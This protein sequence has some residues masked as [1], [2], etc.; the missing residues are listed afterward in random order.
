MKTLTGNCE[1]CIEVSNIDDALLGIGTGTG[2]TVSTSSSPLKSSI[3]HQNSIQNSTQNYSQ[4]SNQNVTQSYENV[5]NELPSIFLKGERP[6]S[7]RSDT[8]SYLGTINTGIGTMLS[9]HEQEELRI[10]LNNEREKTI[11]L[12][13]ALQL[14]DEENNM[15][16]K[17]QMKN[18]N[19]YNN[20]NNNININN[21]ENENGTDKLSARTLLNTT[22]FF[23]SK[24]N[25]NIHSNT[26]MNFNFINLNM[27]HTNTLSR[28]PSRIIRE[29]N[30]R[31][32]WL[33]KASKSSTFTS[34]VSSLSSIWKTKFVELRH[35]VFSYEDD[36]SNTK[37]TNKKNILLS[38]DTCYCDVLKMREKDGDFVFELSMKNGNRRLWQA[39]SIRDRDA[40]INAINSG[41]MRNNDSFLQSNALSINNN[42]NDDSNSNNNNHHNNNTMQFLLDQSMGLNDNKN[43]NNSNNSIITSS[44]G[45]AAP[46]TNEISRFFSIIN[47]IKAIETVDHYKD[48]IDQ[49][50]SIHLKITVPVFFVKN[51][52]DSKSFNPSSPPPE[53]SGNNTMKCDTPR[54]F[55][56][57]INTFFYLF[58]LIFLFFFILFFYFISFF[59]N[60]FLF[61][62]FSFFLFFFLFLFLFFINFTSILFCYLYVKCCHRNRIFNNYFIL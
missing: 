34:S 3:S 28:K 38:S 5:P 50:K 7:L 32:G 25:K 22:D 30:I 31:F 10:A 44:D 60:F 48:I 35:G 54:R 19:E 62:F 59:F 33:K 29:D 53:C 26:N 58:I 36:I 49:L 42:N 14:L 57:Y 13:A 12:K 9:D 47:V 24:A 8:G 52:A 41:M 21:N 51:Q 2:D 61:F 20:N 27:N 56:Y 55:K 43:N 40:W 6:N 23:R 46:Y 17:Y 18:N 16:S 11:F 1:S 4:N 39:A 37:K 45:A 15:I